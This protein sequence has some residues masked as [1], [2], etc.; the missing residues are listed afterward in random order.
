LIALESV[1]DQSYAHWEYIIVDDCSTEPFTHDDDRV[2]VL[3]LDKNTGYTNATNQGILHCG[4]RFKY[5][6]LL[7]ND[8]EPRKDFIKILLEQRFSS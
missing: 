1:L 7:N 8:T 3:R 5:I 4:D 2:E 6:H